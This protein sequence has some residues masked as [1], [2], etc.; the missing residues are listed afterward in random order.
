M[1]QPR[2]TIESFLLLM[3]VS[4]QQLSK[5]ARSKEGGNAEPHAPAGEG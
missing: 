5:S 2:Q 4:G 1:T 3:Q